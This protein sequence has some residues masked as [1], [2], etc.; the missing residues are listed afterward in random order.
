NAVAILPELVDLALVDVLDAGRVTT[1]ENWVAFARER[2]VRSPVLTLARAEIA[3]RHGWHQKSEPMARQA[4]SQFTPSDP[5]YG[6]ANL[7]AGQAAYFND[8]LIEA[9]SSFECVRSCSPEEPTK[10][11]A[12]WWSFLTGIDLEDLSAVEFLTTYERVHSHGPDDAVRVATGHLSLACRLGR[13]SEALDR[14]RSASYVVN[15]ARDPMVRSSFWNAYAWALTLNSRYDEALEAAGQV[16][17][18]A[19]DHDLDFIVPHAE[20]VSAQARPGIRQMLEASR[21]LDEVDL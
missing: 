12:L 7:R 18:E 11:E 9:L 3:F 19:R 5:M 2:K 14:A 8:R 17:A 6:R 15:E 21:L 16:L 20:L 4:V 1:L 10:R 13:I